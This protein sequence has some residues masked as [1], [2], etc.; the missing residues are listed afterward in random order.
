MNFRNTPFSWLWKLAICTVA[1]AAGALLGGILTM[2]LSLEMPRQPGVADQSL[3]IL[4][5]FA[6]GLVYSVGLSAIAIG[7]VGRWWQRWL[8]LAT[9]L[10]G[11]NG[12]GNAIETS[13]F[14]TLGGEVG[15]AVGFLLPSVACAMAVALLFPAPSGVRLAEKSSEFIR[16]WKPLSLGGRVVLA[17]MAFPVIYF[18]FGAAISPIVVPYYEKLEFL[19]TPAMSTLIPILHLR[20]TL[21][22]LVSLPIIIGWDGSRSR[23]ILGLAL[24]HAAA[25]GLGGLVQV[26]F[27][28]DVLRWVHGIEILADSLA[29]AWILALLF[30]AGTRT[31]SR[32]GEKPV[33]SGIQ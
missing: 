25:V 3:Q 28:P 31:K 30:A 4:L 2:A 5:L 26:T 7:L 9:F 21:L 27:F 8:I 23:L 20:S 22:L 14:T 33:S 15:Q 18:I 11:I 16:R 6:G 24:G 1:Y 17:V 12:I 13:I 10:F 19:T 32:S 29:Y